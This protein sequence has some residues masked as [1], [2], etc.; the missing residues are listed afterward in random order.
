MKEAVVK[1]IKRGYSS[2]W[3]SAWWMT[4][5]MIPITI[6]V[7]LL[8][9]TGLIALLSRW[10]GPAFEM[11]GLSGEAVVV[12]LTNALSNLYSG[13]AVI[14][15][16]DLDFRQATILAVMGL[17]CHNLIVETIIQRKAGANG[18]FIVLLRIGMAIIAA[19]GLNFVL[20]ADFTGR[21]IVES[22]VAATGLGA[23]FTEWGL[24]MLKLVP[25]MFV[26]IV[27][28]NILQQ[29]LREFKLIDLLTVPLRPLMKIFGL[30]RETSFLW[31]VLNT[32]GL[33]YGGGV[34][35]A[36]LSEGQI[37][38][39]AA[40]ML[41][42]HVAIT[43]SLLEDTLIFVAIGLPAL[44]LIVPRAILSIG[45]VWGQRLYYQISNRRGTERVAPICLQYETKS[46][47]TK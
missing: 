40:S 30:P 12:F 10:L 18:L 3:R 17:I 20:P 42:T 5:M 19:V 28:L 36:E 8:K 35:I 16:L 15:T 47:I 24:S 44:W 4:K 2:G 39:R 34:L 6:L 13:I 41:N 26:L 38:P 32:L 1:C 7:A 46:K 43:H 11:L 27:T 14:A 37:K 29:L 21:L 33:A 9:W 31:I 22:S 25:M 23:I 45:A